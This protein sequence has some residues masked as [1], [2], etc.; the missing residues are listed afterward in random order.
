MEI[1]W[2]EFDLDKVF[3]SG[4]DT[5]GESE[6]E[7][8]M[9]EAALL[10]GI[11]A[12]IADLPGSKTVDVE[13]K[14]ASQETAP[15]TVEDASYPQNTSGMRDLAESVRTPMVYDDQLKGSTIGAPT[16]GMIAV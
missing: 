11:P 8:V 6:K 13:T 16:G 7:K 3:A 2:A 10:T 15:S 1:R 9:D 4:R 12:D 14:P 5:F